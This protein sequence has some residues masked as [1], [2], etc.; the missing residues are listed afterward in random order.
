MRL[1]FLRDRRVGILGYGREGRA[2]LAVIRR[3]GL[4]IAPTVL[5]EDGQVPEGSPA[6]RAPFA[7]QLLDFDVLLRSPGIRVEHPALVRFRAR[8]GVVVNPG[9]IFFSERPDARVIGVTGSKGKSTTAALLAHLLE[10]CG[11][12]SILAGNIGVPLLDHLE[13]PRCLVVAEL[14]SYQ[15]SDLEGRLTMGVMTRL[16]DEHLDWHGSRERYHASKLRMVDLL[17][18]HPLLVNATDPVLLAATK[19]VGGRVACNQPP[20]LHR[21]RGGIWRDG[22][23]RIRERDLGLI[24][25]HN[26]DNAVLALE[27][28]LRLDCP[29]QDLEQA[30]AAFHPLPHRLENLGTTAARHWINDSIATSPHATRAALDALQS[31]PVT[32]IAGGQRR[33]ADWQ[34]VADALADRGLAGLVTLPE[35]GRTIAKQLMEAGLISGE[36]V[37]VAADMELAVEAAVRLSEPGGTVVLSPGAPSFP[38]YRDFEER[39][40][41]FRAAIARYKDRSTA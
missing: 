40:E 21:R 9:S 25:R 23:C 20:G 22:S 34:V 24:G 38:I 32:L 35:N 11:H 5:V 33:P 2:A 10:A 18:G 4:K 41:R 3:F 27:A 28:A 31:G 14:S 39:G 17:G 13:S 12:E 30:V 1:E 19:G 7:D 36:R 16:F 15:L 6:I 8:G 37:H 29:V 26:L